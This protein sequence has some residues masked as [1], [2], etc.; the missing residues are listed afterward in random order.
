MKKSFKLFIDSLD[1]LEELTDEQAGQLF[2]AIRAYEVDG[3]E[4]LTGLMKAI[5]TPFKHNIDRAK[6]EYEAVCE[7]NK[8]N[9]LKGGRPNPVKPSGLESPPVKADKDK[10]KDKDTIYSDVISH[11]NI[12]TGKSYK[13]NSNKTKDLIT[14][15]INDGFLLDD[16]VK[17]IDNKSNEWLDTEYEKFLRPETLFSNKFEGYLNQRPIKKE[18]DTG[19]W[20]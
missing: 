20:K 16:F 3:I 6:A 14:A 15:R 8:A 7:R 19:G 10:D 4:I 17:V 1:V 9:G 5:F 2:R 12:K 11:L 18:N 13:S